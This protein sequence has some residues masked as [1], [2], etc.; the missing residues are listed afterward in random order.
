M[1]RKKLDVIKEIWSKLRDPDINEMDKSLL[2]I[3]E[4]VCIEVFFVFEIVVEQ[5]LVDPG[6]AGNLVGAGAGYA[7]VGKFFQRRLQDGGARL[8]R[9]AA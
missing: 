6:A 8:F 2:F 3:L 1:K 4:L 7:L 9:L 5:R